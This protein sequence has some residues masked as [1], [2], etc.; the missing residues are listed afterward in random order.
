LGGWKEAEEEEDSFKTKRVFV[1][2]RRTLG[3]DDD[4]PGHQLILNGLTCVTHR[5]TTSPT[6]VIV[7]D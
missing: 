7:T 5:Q 4:D 2:N 1:K 6:N 3:H